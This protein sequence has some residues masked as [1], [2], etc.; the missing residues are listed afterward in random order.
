MK[1]LIDADIVA[2]QSAA[3]AEEVTDWGNDMWTLHSDMGQAKEAFNALIDRIVVGS[4]FPEA[5][6]I[7]VY[8]CLEGGNWRKEE[9]PEYKANRKGKRKPIVYK[10]LVKWSMDEWTS[11][12][13]RCLE[14]DDLMGILATREPE[15]TIICS[16]DK[17]M[18]T[19]P[20][21]LYNWDKDAQPQE[22]SHEEA[23]MSLAYQALIGDSTD[24]YKG[25]PGCGPVAATKV[26]KDVDPGDEEDVWM[27]VWA[28]YKKKGMDVDEMIQQSRLARICQD[29][30]WNFETMTMTWSP[31]L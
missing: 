12:H 11:E 20:C 15:D 21:C 5:E 27:A 31:N 8:S 10:E 17:D 2:F 19:I 26:L 4:D 3:A 7:L 18:K 1:L 25:L 28:A 16:I 13:S 6:V 9:F 14:A 24:G 22:V 30:D 29:G 23:L